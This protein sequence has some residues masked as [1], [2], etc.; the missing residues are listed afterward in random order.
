MGRFATATAGAAFLATAGLLTFGT[1]QTPPS[2]SLSPALAPKQL[3]KKA[4]D[5]GPLRPPP[6]VEL[7]W[8]VAASKMDS[9]HQRVNGVKLDAEAKVDH[10]PK[11]DVIVVAWTISYDGPRPPLIIVEPT[12]EERTNGTTRVRLYAVPEGKKVGWGCELMSPFREPQPNPPM[13]LF[14]FT[15]LVVPKEL[16]LEVRAD[17]PAKGQISIPATELRKSLA[18]RKADK[19]FD[20]EKPPRLFLEVL[21]EPSDRGENFALDAWTG[22]LLSGVVEVPQLKSW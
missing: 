10:K 20:P 9:R 12:L 4:S 18:A 8:L 3:E 22:K 7:S 11:G 1:A 16:F 19:F 6:E 5:E 14:G 13:G 2:G 21:H 17:K 15:D